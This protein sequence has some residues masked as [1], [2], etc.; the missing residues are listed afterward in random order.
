M[1]LN[2]R[3]SVRSFLFGYFFAISLK[4]L[5]VFLLS[6]RYLVWRISFY[7]LYGEFLCVS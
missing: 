2:V 3:I 5:F 1:Q 6:V 4:Y 7:F